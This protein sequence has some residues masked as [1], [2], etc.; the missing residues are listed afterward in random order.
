MKQNIENMKVTVCALSTQVSKETPSR[1]TLSFQ[2]LKNLRE[3][4]LTQEEADFSAEHLSIVWW[5][6]NE[7]KLPANDWFDIVI[8]RYLLTV[9][10][11]FA[12]PEL[13]KYSFTTLVTAAMCSA[14]N[15][16]RRKQ[17]R[18]PHMFSLDAPYKGT[19]GDPLVECLAG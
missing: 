13:H 17:G 8:F 2:E 14:V 16:E 7:Y 3:R 1:K 6:L 15:T 18:H 19:Y 11:W 10:R 9:K 12:L 5:F 4:R